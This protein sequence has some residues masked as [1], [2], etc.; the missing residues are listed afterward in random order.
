VGDGAEKKRIQELAK[1]AELDSIIFVE[2]QP[3]DR[4]PEFIH[5]C[6]A[7]AV[8]L[9]KTDLFQTV[10]PT[11]MLEFM[12]CG[13]P[14]L[15]GVDGQA[16]NIMEQARAGVFVEPENA[17]ALVDAIR[18]LRGN[19]ELCEALARNGRDYILAHYSR[20]QTASEYVALIESVLGLAGSKAAA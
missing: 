18:H 13:R 8:L 14:V 17:S 4:I 2:Q 7:C 12:S 9:R 20:Q 3:R 6:D 15:L 1:A 16:R 11:K 19:P 5:A 10:I